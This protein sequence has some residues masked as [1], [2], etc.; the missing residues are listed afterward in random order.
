MKRSRSN[1]LGQALTATGTA[2]AA[3]VI[4]NQATNAQEKRLA[5]DRIANGSVIDYVE[6]LYYKKG[7]TQLF[8]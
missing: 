3:P 4:F 2:I 7:S 1:F 6:V 8:V 5:T